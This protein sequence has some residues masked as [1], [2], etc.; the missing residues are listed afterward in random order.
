MKNTKQARAAYK[1][2]KYSQS[3]DLYTQ[4]AYASLSHDSLTEAVDGQIAAGLYFLLQAA[5]G[6][7]CAEQHDRTTNRC[8]QGILILSDIQANVI[9]DTAREAILSEYSGDFKVLGGIQRPSDAYEEAATKY[10]EAG[11]TESFSWPSNPLV[12]KN[13]TF[14][15]WILRENNI[16]LPDGLDIEYNFTDRLSY[17]EKHMNSLVKID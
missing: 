12:D 3:G 5:W 2:G 11:I 8:R 9:S 6:Y 15:T 17:K 14:F 7:R 13:V 16:S 10:A 1:S 4:A